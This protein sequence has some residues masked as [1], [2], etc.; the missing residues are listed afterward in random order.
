MS[1]PGGPP[2]S[3][4]HVGMVFVVV[5]PVLVLVVPVL[6]LVLLLI[7]I[8]TV[9]AR[10]FASSTSVARSPELNRRRWPW[11]RTNYH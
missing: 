9:V 5:V 4:S 10:R 8:T 6:V 1:T 3:I 7:T 2:L 11:P